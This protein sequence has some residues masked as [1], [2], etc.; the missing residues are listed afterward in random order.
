MVYFMENPTYKWMRTQISVLKVIEGYTVILSPI[1]T[2]VYIYN[3]Y[4]YIC[5]YEYMYI[6][7]CISECSMGNPNNQPVQENHR[8]IISHCSWMERHRKFGP[9]DRGI[10]HLVATLLGQYM[11]YMVYIYL[12]IYII[13]IY[14]DTYGYI[15]IYTYIYNI[16]IWG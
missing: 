6:Y 1:Y 3:V 2:Y 11:V 7:I 16:H 10:K 14:M 8:G 12:Y 5:I 13:Y 15:Y 9:W 4:M